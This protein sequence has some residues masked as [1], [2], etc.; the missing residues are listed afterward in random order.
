MLDVRL[1]ARMPAQAILAWGR[2]PSALKAER[3][4]IWV[5]THPEVSGGLNRGY[6]SQV[7]AR[8][9]PQ[10]GQLR[11]LCEIANPIGLLQQV[12]KVYVAT[13]GMG[14]EALLCGKLVRCFGLPWYAGLGVT[15]DEQR[16]V[17][18]IRA[19]SVRELFA[20][21]HLPYTRYL[22]PVAD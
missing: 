12:K 3:L 21:A 18:R 9:L 11:L 5:K 10:G 2:K 6:L 16:C 7:Q 1:V 20:A 13:S 22:N 19:R 17:R 14:F 8:A 15:K 4:K